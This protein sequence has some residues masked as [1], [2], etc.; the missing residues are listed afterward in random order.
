MSVNLKK[1]SEEEEKHLRASI[2]EMETKIA[3]RSEFM[4][5]EQAS[6]AEWDDARRSKYDEAVIEH[7]RLCRDR[8]IAKDQLDRMMP[9][10]PDEKLPE[11]EETNQEQALEEFLRKG[12]GPNGI[13]EVDLGMLSRKQRAQ[14]AQ[15]VLQGN[16]ASASAI[17]PTDTAND[18]VS[19]LERFGDAVMLP[20][21]LVTPSGNPVEYPHADNTAQEGEIISPTAQGTQATEQDVNN[22]GFETM[23]A[24]TVSSKRTS[25]PL[26][27]TA[28]ANFDVTGFI[29]GSLTQRIGRTIDKSIIKGAGGANAP[30]GI[31]GVAKTV[32]MASAT[33]ISPVVDFINMEFEV[34]RGYLLGEGGYA[35]GR[36]AGDGLMAR[37]GH[38]G[39]ALSREAEKLARRATDT[40]GRPL[41]EPSL[42]VGGPARLFGWPVVTSEQI[43][44]P[45]SG[46]IS[47]YFGNFGYMLMRT[48]SG[49][50][51]GNLQI[52]S[53]YD[54]GT[55]DKNTVMFVGFSRFDQRSMLK[56]DGSSKNEAIIGG[57]HG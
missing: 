31:E 28:D 45:A 42:Q 27:L 9:L 38:V 47:C 10:K 26:E 50:G 39:F 14:R 57:R 7:G 40:R 23:K 13:F 16:G 30:Q 5:A 48:V 3:E 56:P 49:G 24:F 41:W 11:V 18:V 37:G 53:F 6:D 12:E 44:A 35:A 29:V 33:G 43:S 22:F 55:A 21:I 34:N 17:V 8:E 46:N 15:E 4:N 19:S 52:K 51:T 54:S 1:W 36:M 20:S 2:D 25:L 32:A